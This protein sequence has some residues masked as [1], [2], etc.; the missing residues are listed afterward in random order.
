MITQ[1]SGHNA[2]T[3]S[4]IGWLFTIPLPTGLEG[5]GVR[6]GTVAN[7]ARWSHTNQSEFT[8]MKL[9]KSVYKELGI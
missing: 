4:N 8:W 5:L 6:C 2:V 3:S 9:H 1:Y 7:S